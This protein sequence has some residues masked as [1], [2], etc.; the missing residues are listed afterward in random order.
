MRTKV[1]AAM[2]LCA[3]PLT[4]LAGII[5]LNDRK[6]YIISMLIIVET[7]LPFA[8]VFEGRRPKAR[9][10]VIIAVL[11]AIATAGRSAFFMLPQVKPVVAVVIIAGVAFGGEAGFLV[12]AMTGFVS[13]MFFG[14]GPWTPWQ[15][16][17]FGIIGFLAGTLFHKGLLSRNTPALAAFGGVTTFLIYG[18]IMDTA[19]V[20][21]YQA[22]PT[23]EM[24]LTAYLSGVPFNLIHAGATVLFLAL[25]ARPML[26]K[27]DRIKLKY[28]LVEAEKGKAKPPSEALPVPS[29]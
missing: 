14:Q 29:G 7:M 22:Q 28:G 4:I 6:Y 26:E 1:A 8:L 9:E 3:I 20:F 25:I 15:M 5:L 12:G 21:M 16:F 19:A 11:C 13:N 10:I 27:L 2:I 17:S 18:S 23:A 24:F